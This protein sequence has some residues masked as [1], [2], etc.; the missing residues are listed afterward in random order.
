[1]L[2]L[3]NAFSV[4]RGASR[5]VFPQHRR[6]LLCRSALGRDVAAAI[7]DVAVARSNYDVGLV[8]FHLDVSSIAGTR[9]RLGIVAHAVLSS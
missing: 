8:H 4:N 5:E 1:M 2:K 3:A 9:W 7:E 6:I